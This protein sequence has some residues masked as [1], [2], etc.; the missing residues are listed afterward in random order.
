MKLIS[1]HIENFG[2][3]SNFDHDF[4][5]GKNIIHEDNGWGMCLSVNA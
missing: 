5:S 2:K 1:A 3:I 4:S